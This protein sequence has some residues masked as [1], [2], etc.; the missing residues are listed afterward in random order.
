M[1]SKGKFAL[2]GCFCVLT[3]ILIVLLLRVD[4]API[5]PVNTSVGL[6][7]LNGAVHD[8]TGV[9]WTWYKITG[10]LGMSELAV[11]AAFVLVGLWQLIR[12]RSLAKVDRE[13][14]ALGGLYVVVGALYVLFDKVAVN[15][16]PVLMAGETFPESSFPSSHTLLV[17]TVLG[18]AIMVMGRFVK[19]DDLRKILRVACG[20]VIV[21]TVAGRLISGVHWLTDIIGGILISIA[22]L[23]QFSG[24]LDILRDKQRQ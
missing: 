13:I 22:L 7:H 21:V 12:R 14:F 9:N 1:R 15:Y 17:C 24:V 8:M 3:V 18:S 19:N 4:V 6:S 16:R 5:G 20:I 23:A 11:V 10:V 2:A